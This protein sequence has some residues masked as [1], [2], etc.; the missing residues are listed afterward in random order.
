MAKLDQLPRA[1]SSGWIAGDLDARDFSLASRTPLGLRVLESVDRKVL[2]L[3]PKKEHTLHLEHFGDVRNQGSLNACCAFAGVSLMEYRVRRE[4]ELRD[5]DCSP[6]FLYK[7]TRDLLKKSGQPNTDGNVPTDSRTT[8]KAMTLVGVAPEKMFETSEANLD[9]EP[10]ALTYAVAANYKAK[11]Y[12][13]LD[14]GD[15]RGEALLQEI[16]RLLMGDLP[17][18]FTVHFL[19]ETTLQEFAKQTA[20][21]PRI[22]VPPAAQIEALKTLRAVAGR[23]I[24]Q[25]AVPMASAA[26]GVAPVDP[27]TRAQQTLREVL[28][29]LRPA[30]ARRNGNGKRNRTNGG[31]TPRAGSPKPAGPVESFV[32]HTL[33]ACGF[34]DRS[35]GILVRNS[36]SDEWAPIAK[37]PGYGWLPYEYVT[38]GL[39]EDW[40]FISDVSFIDPAI[41]AATPPANVT[42]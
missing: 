13:R 25:D 6:G 28:D 3:P 34:D 18:M 24:P 27:Q 39:T 10:D 36:W 7:V 23:L 42:R 1:A 4:R 40:W 37:L 26:A 33:V 5:A 15:V 32:G 11:A 21:Q 31:G 12:W 29:A 16:K 30:E 35:R 2:K 9:R 41:F 17:L 14:V 19:V 22:P 38:K 8:M 20:R